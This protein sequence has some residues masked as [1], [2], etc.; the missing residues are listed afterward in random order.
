MPQIPLYVSIPFLL[1]S[2]SLQFIFEKMELS[3]PIDFPT[4]GMLI[5]ASM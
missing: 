3:A 5:T 2:N 4:L 1:K